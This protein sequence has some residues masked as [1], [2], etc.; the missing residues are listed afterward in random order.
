MGAHQ[1]GQ[2]FTPIDTTTVCSPSGPPHTP[3]DADCGV[4]LIN[5]NEDEVYATVVLSSAQVCLQSNLAW[6]QFGFFISPPFFLSVLNTS[7]LCYA[8]AFLFITALYTKMKITTYKN[9]SPWKKKKKKTQI[10]A[11][12]CKDLHLPS[13]Q[14][15]LFT[16]YS[17]YYCLLH[18]NL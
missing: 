11:F 9:H 5:S 7:S 3:W 13:S 8:S 14:A 16:Y 10:D 15:S 6:C 17:L 12:Y 1:G 2:P 4:L 18:R